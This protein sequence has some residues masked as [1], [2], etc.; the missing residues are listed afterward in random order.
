VAA[1]RVRARLASQ[2]ANKLAELRAALPGW[3]IEPLAADGWPDETGAT[4]EENAR[5][6]A[7]FGLEVAGAG[8]WVLGEDSGI[9]CDALGGEPGLHSARWAPRGDQ[10]DA[11]LERLRGEPNRRARMVAALV[12]LS[13]DG[14]ELSGSGV[15][16]GAIA[17][18]RRG[19]GGFGYDPIF[20][21]DDGDRERTV[22][23]L[24]DDWKREH[25]HRAKA[26]KA[27][28]TA[29]RRRERH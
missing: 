3:E 10:A 7:R 19:V 17:L 24:G 16:E 28:A 22:A 26:A 11:L 9:E 20:V 4:Y 5:L 14:E 8:A 21:P 29:L 6:K 2:N 23:E 25:S 12:A 13:H 15:L 27:L 1:L 18:E